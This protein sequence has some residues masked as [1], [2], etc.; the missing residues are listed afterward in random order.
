MPTPLGDRIRELRI[1]RGLT[2]DGLAEKVSSSKS[3]IW[4]LENKNV[5][6]PSAEKLRLIAMALDTTTDYLLS[7]E[8]V[9]EASASDSVFFRQ[10]QG[11]KEPTKKKLQAIMKML[12]EDDVK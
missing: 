5:A 10:Y 2:L 1:K 3:Y 12:D 11:L 8:E 4:E 9:T 6:R 7:A